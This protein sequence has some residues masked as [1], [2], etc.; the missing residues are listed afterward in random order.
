MSVP[1]R[2]QTLYTF[3]SEVNCTDGAAASADLPLLIDGSGDLLGTTLGGGAN[4]DD[5]TVFELTP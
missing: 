5:G 3:C 1:Y 4:G 2:E